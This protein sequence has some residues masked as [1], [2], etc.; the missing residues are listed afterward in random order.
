MS[1][2]GH[3]TILAGDIGG[4]KAN[5]AFFESTADRIHPLIEMTLPSGDYATL[6][7]LI[8]EFLS[9][10]NLKADVTCLSIAGPIVHGHCKATNLPWTIDTAVLARN[11]GL[12]HITLINDLEANAY[13]IYLLHESD[14]VVINHGDKKAYGNAA[15]ISAGTGLGEA[16]I[17]WDGTKMR[18][19]ACE[20]GHCD[21]APAND[22]QLELL[23]FLM[24]KESGH[25]SYERLVSGMG[26]VNIYKYLLS[27][28]K[29][30]EPEWLV[31]QIHSP[32]APAAISGA[33]LTNKSDIC[34]DAL[35]IFIDIFGAETGNLALKM[36]ATGGVFIGGGIAPKMIN[37]LS[38]PRFMHSFLDKGRL[39]PVLE[40]M[41]IRVIMNEKA[42]LMGAARCAT[43][44]HR[45]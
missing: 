15:V 8:D 28:G 38:E 36:M 11:L 41:P 16:G 22:V 14:F 37:K 3:Y 26:I 7:E 9:K 40:V 12:E 5:L 2:I 21:F 13:G 10:T 27:T 1:G 24:K 17:Y 30:E 43:M 25:V 20:G 45:P 33:A 6:H 31:D 39:R 32:D 23:K 34:V 18:P 4:T 29:Y 35:D 42:A 19:F 44:L